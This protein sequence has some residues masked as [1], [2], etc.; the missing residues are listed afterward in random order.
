MSQNSEAIKEKMSIF[1]YLK[2]ILDVETHT[3]KVNPEDM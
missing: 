2:K 1:E 3:H